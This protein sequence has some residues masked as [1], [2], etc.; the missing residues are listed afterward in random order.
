MGYA[1][2]KRRGI[3]TVCYGETV[4]LD[5][6]SYDEAVETIVSAIRLISEFHRAESEGGHAD[7]N[8]H[9]VTGDRLA[10]TCNVAEANGNKR[11][12]PTKSV[13]GRA[14]PSFGFS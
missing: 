10:Q 13:I 7:A 8:P 6:A 1:L 5:F 9:A 3:W 14:S 11:Y 12:I 4:L 2:R